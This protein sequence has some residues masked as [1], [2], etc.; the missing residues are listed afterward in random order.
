MPHKL[1][2]PIHIPLSLSNC[3]STSDVEQYMHHIGWNRLSSHWIDSHGGGYSG[4]SKS[5]WDKEGTSQRD[6]CAGHKRKRSVDATEA[7][8][9]KIARARADGNKSD[10]QLRVLSPTGMDSRAGLE[11]RCGCAEVGV[12]LTSQQQQQQQ[13][14]QQPFRAVHHGARLTRPAK[15]SPHS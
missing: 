12:A 7:S 9:G 4:F 11:L 14:Q 8:P 3:D 15:I 1:H 5:W 13:Q 10:G 2:V 6:R